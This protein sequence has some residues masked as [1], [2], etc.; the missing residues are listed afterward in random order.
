[1]GEK[2]FRTEVFMLESQGLKLRVFIAVPEPL[3]DPMP[4]VQI[5]HG[6]GG[7]EPIY[8]EMAMEMAANGFVGAAMI[9]RGYAGSEG[10]ME[11]GKGEILDIK[12]LTDEL[13]RRPDPMW[14]KPNR[15]HRLLPRGAQRSPCHG[16][17]GL[18]CRRRSVE[19]AGGH[20]GT[21]E[22]RALDQPHHR[23]HAR[24]NTGRISYPFFHPFCVSNQLPR[25]YPSR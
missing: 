8:E 5:H 11:Y 23:R 17:M 3:E 13:L 10:E 19:C 1:M 25:S 2:P 15:D 12:N 4:L 9:H 20:A 14:M 21:G 6:G 16:K 7:Y 18:F 24:R 22:G